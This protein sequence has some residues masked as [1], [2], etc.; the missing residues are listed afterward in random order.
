MSYEKRRQV[1]S[2]PT[3]FTTRADE[4]G[5]PYIEGYFVVFDDT[6][7]ITDWMSESIASGAFDKTLDND[8]RALLNHNADVVLGRNKAGTLE[9][10]VDEKGLWCKIYINAEDT[11]AMDVYRR[12]QRGDINQCS[13]GF[14]ILDEE[15]IQKPDGSVHWLVKEVYLYEVS[16]CTFPAYEETDI[17]ARSK[18]RDKLIAERI[19]TRKKHIKEVIHGFKSADAEKED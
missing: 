7:I 10:R 4:N 17:V 6:Y 9:L 19:E 15:P 2:V 14:D 5:S 1:R 13:F 16:V 12:V 3:K 8:I 18:Q 11:Q